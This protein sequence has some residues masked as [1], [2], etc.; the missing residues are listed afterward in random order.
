MQELGVGLA[1]LGQELMDKGNSEMKLRQLFANARIR[2]LIAAQP[3]IRFTVK[4][5]ERWFG[6]ALPESVDELYFEVVGVIKEIE[7]LNIL[8]ELFA[9]TCDQL[10]HIGSGYEQ[11]PNVRTC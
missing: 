4:D 5:D 9:E 8:Y 10:V 3:A 2:E 6:A 1:G 11:K 7:Q